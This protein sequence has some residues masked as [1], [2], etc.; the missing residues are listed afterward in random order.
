MGPAVAQMEGKSKSPRRAP[1]RAGETDQA[2]ALAVLRWVAADCG[3][4]LTPHQAI[5]QR[6]V[7]RSILGSR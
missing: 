1:P 5:I 6:A 3:V 2:A 4:G 7:E